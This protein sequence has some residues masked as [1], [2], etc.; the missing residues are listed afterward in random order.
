MVEFKN[1]TP[2]Q[3]WQ[4]I[5]KG[6]HP[7]WIKGI[8]EKTRDLIEKCW[9]S[10]VD[11]RPTF[12]E[13]FE[14]LSQDFSYSPEDVDSEEIDLYIEKIKSDEKPVEDDVKSKCVDIFKEQINSY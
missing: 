4:R 12:E 13:I 14:M 5:I 2:Y 10:D 11:E 1:L 8:P 6:S 3:F 7:T 9:S